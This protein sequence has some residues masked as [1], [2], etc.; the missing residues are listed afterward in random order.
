MFETLIATPSNGERTDGLRRLHTNDDARAELV[1]R[2]GESFGK[3]AAPL[4]NHVVR[5]TRP[6]AGIAIEQQHRAHSRTER[7]G[8]QVDC[9][10]GVGERRGCQS[11]GLFGGAGRAQTGLHETGSWLLGDDGEVHA[12]SAHQN[13][14]VSSRK[15]RPMSLTALAVPR[16]VPVTFDRPARS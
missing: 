6:V 4:R 10:E 9:V 3:A 5:G 7:S 11:G 15:S 16:T 2:V 1:E 8:H 13:D 12:R 14:D